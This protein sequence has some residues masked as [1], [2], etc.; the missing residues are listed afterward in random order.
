M[1][2][3]ASLLMDNLHE[4]DLWCWIGSIPIIED[5]NPEFPDCSVDEPDLCPKTGQTPNVYRYVCR[6]HIMI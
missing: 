1:T 2:A 6:D 5:D 3:L 4:A